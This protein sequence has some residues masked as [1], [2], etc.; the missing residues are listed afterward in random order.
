MAVEGVT[1]SRPLLIVVVRLPR[2]H[3]LQIGI[4]AWLLPWPALAAEPPAAIVDYVTSVKPILTTRCYKCHGASQQKAGLRLDTAAMLRTGGD[5]G[6]GYVAGEAEKSLLLQVITGAHDDIAPMP[7]KKPPLPAAEI[8]VI[9]R[10]IA[11]GAHAPAAEEPEKT[12]HWAF[13]PPERSPPPAVQDAAWPRHDLDRFV[14]ARLEAEGLR[15]AP[16]AEKATLLRRVTLDLIGLPPT[17]AEVDAFVVDRAPGAYARVVERLLASPHFGERWARPWLD[18]ARYAD[19]NGYS[20]DAPRQIW[21]YRDW[22][23]GALN[24]DLPYDQFVIEQLGGDLLPNP[25]VDQKVATGFNRNTQINQEGGIDPEQ[26][27]IE[28]VL[29]R[30]ST[31]GTV[32]LGLTVGC[33]QC[34][35]HKFD[36]IKQREYYQLYAIFNNSADDGHGK[37]APGST[38]AFASENPA[39]E[40]A[41]RELETQQA[42]FEKFLDA[43]SAPVVAWFSALDGLGKTNLGG[44][45]REALDVAWTDLTFAQKRAVFA[46]DPQAEPEFKTRNQK[47]SALERKASRRLT[48]LVMSELKT[49]RESTIFIK[50]DFTRRGDP[51]QPGTPAILPPMA[52]ATP[53]RLDLARWLFQPEHPLTARVMV[54][55]IWQQYFGRG[56]VETENDF[57]T[58][59]LAP[60]QPELLDFLSTE[61]IAQKWSMKALHRLIVSSA[62]Y[63]QSSRERPDLHVVDPLNKFLAHQSR[64]RL[65]AEIVRDVA[66]AASG[67]LAPQLGGP[68]VYPPQPDGVMNLGQSS[69]PWIAST[70]HDRYRRGLYTHYWRATPHPAAAVFDAADS[71]SACTRRLR[72]NT[73][74]QA[75]TLLNDQQF[76]EFAGALAKRVLAEGGND[77]SA[78]LDYAFRLCV[79]RPPAPKERTRLLAL[80]ADLRT[81]R[82]TDPAASEAE[83]WTTIARVLLNLDETITR[84]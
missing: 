50:G 63:R 58:Q 57:G 83:A 37:N 66:L 76:F 53:N 8:E 22:V 84:E 25:T 78:R 10:W 5:T 56:L 47:F 31:F 2:T 49:P 29:D 20:V 36:P 17:L 48:T 75:L 77:D 46:A 64:L 27:R 52:V 82:A 21:K 55:R 1:N 42:A 79:A 24:R 4:L 81:P 43:R 73:P 44:T 6:S 35:D 15:P 34:H 40:A 62:T 13:V 7:Y 16:E 19:S 80:L 71:F 32:F 33:A 26:F 41:M 3:L 67:L 30:V 65:D 39:D 51:V 11:Q 69:R 68:P 9:R 12:K 70:G 23:V 74:L 45:A 72:S 54:N 18:V 60:S 38:L 61:F 59:G 28:S 14:L